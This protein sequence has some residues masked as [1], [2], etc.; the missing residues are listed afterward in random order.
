MEAIE[1]P[2]MQTALPE[3]IRKRAGWLAVLFVGELFTSTAMQHYEISI[4]KVGALS[5][6]LPLIIS[7]GGNSGSQAT[8]LICARSRCARFRCATGGALCC[9]SCPPD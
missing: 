5:L 6:F 8:S 3:M 9:A 2:Y 1:F 4:E 7:S